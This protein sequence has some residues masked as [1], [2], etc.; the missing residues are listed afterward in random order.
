MPKAGIIAS[1]EI[2]TIDI[3]DAIK[4]INS[5]KQQ[6]FAKQVMRLYF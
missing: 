4:V 5:F 2:A 1:M 6:S 3:N